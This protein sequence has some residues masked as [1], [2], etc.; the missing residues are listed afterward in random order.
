MVTGDD[1]NLSKVLSNMAGMYSYEYKDY[2]KALQLYKQS[3][4]IKIKLNDLMGIAMQNHNLGTLYGNMEEYNKAQ[5][6][7]EISESL[8]T[9]MESKTGLVMVYYSMGKLYEK[10][11]NHREALSFYSKSLNIASQIG[12][13]EYLLDN[14]EAMFKCYAAIGDYSNFSKYYKMFEIGND[15]LLENLHRAEMLEM[16]ARFKVDQLQQQGMMLAEDNQVMESEL[17]KY[18]L[19]TFAFGGIIVFSL[20]FYFLYVIFRR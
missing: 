11:S 4:E 18:R 14:Y 8:Y 6:Y 5:K 12:Q 1:R 20:V 2:I 16:E 10:K 13:N 17:K 3:L 15:T 9:E 7:F 19:L